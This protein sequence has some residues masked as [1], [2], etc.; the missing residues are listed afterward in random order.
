[1]TSTGERS[2]HRR[3]RDDR[4][5]LADVEHAGVVLELVARVAAQ[6]RVADRHRARLVVA[7][8]ED[9]AAA[10]L[11][12]VLLDD[13]PVDGQLDLLAVH[14]DGAA[15]AAAGGARAGR[16]GAVADRRVAGEDAVVDGPS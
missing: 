10:L 5:S 4:L 1:A 6:L 7:D 2:A 14:V 16:V 11:G 13:G 12:V 9:G 8:E 15:A 3:A